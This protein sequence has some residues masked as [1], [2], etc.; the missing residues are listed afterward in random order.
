[1]RISLTHS[2]WFIMLSALSVSSCGG[3]DVRTV[4]VQLETANIG[5]VSFTTAKAR[6]ESNEITVYGT[7]CGNYDPLQPWGGGIYAGGRPRF[8]EFEVEESQVTKAEALG[9]KPV[10]EQML[11]MRSPPEGRSC[12]PSE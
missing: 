7:R 5:G 6:L 12:D 8:F 4:K 10:T 9:F 3:G 11:A 1:M 2:C